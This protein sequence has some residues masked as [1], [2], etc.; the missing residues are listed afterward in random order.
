MASQHFCR[1][2]ARHPE[3]SQPHSSVDSRFLLIRVRLAS[4]LVAEWS[5]LVSSH[6][7]HNL[8]QRLRL[9]GKIGPLPPNHGTKLLLVGED[10][11]LISRRESSLSILQ[12]VFVQDPRYSRALCLV[13]R[14]QVWHCLPFALRGGFN[15]PSLAFLDVATAAS[16]RLQDQL[17]VSCS[18]L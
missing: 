16:Q 15:F 5:Q 18:N 7:P 9:A 11:E 3:F 17:E 10:P 8:P 1:C 4:M 2:S 12:L 6:L 13:F 14:Q